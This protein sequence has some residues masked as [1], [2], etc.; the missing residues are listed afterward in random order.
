MK[1]LLIALTASASLILVGCNSD[2]DKD[3]NEEAPEINTSDIDEARASFE[4]FEDE[5]ASKNEEEKIKE[6]EKK[7]NKDVRKSDALSENSALNPPKL[8]DKEKKKGEEYNLPDEYKKFKKDTEENVLQNF[9]YLGYDEDNYLS[10]G[11]KIY[12]RY[13]TG[14]KDE[15]KVSEDEAEKAKSFFL[16]GARELG[17]LPGLDNTRPRVGEDY[18]ALKKLADSK[19]NKEEDFLEDVAKAQNNYGDPKIIDVTRDYNDKGLYQV[20]F[21]YQD[22]NGRAMLNGITYYFVDV[23][24][25]E[26]LQIQRAETTI[27]GAKAISDWVDGEIGSTN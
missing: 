5:V 27:F 3:N 17:E 15:D 7:E 22:D 10:V 9:G 18:E 24:D 23:L 25:K 14:K 20:Q 12:H 26:Q 21:E 11:D 13:V 19:F 4:Q 1:R 16:D 8:T 6:Q 2:S